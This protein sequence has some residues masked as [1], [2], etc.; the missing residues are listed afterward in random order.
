MEVPTRLADLAVSET[1]F[2]FDPYTGATFTANA[3]GLAILRHL[4]A[5]V[6]RT[7]VIEQLEDEFELRGAD[8]QRDLDD[9][10]HQLEQNDLLPRHFSLE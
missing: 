9:F 2:V 1:G 4:K 10:L 6:S 5:G 8:P 7:E 3:T